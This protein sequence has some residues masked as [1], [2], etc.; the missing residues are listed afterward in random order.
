LVMSERPRSS[1]AM[2]TFS[3][4]SRST[5]YPRVENSG[6]RIGALVDPDCTLLRLIAN[7]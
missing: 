3:R 7:A 1:A 6:L 5:I 4:W 2:S